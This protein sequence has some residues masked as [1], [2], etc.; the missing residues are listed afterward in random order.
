MLVA[1]RPLHIFDQ[2]TP[3]IAMSLFPSCSFVVFYS[4]HIPGHVFHLLAVSP[5]HH[6][7]PSN[8]LFLPCLLFSLVGSL[9]FFNHSLPPIFFNLSIFCFLPTLLA[10]LSWI[11]CNSFALLCYGFVKVWKNCYINC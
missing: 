3:V 1:L 5:D 7:V 4:F 10:S 9:V 6:I 8:I 2:S 11:S